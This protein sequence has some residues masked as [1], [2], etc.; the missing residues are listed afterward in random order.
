MR[1]HSAIRRRS[2]ASGSRRVARATPWLARW[3]LAA[4]LALSVV[5]ASGGRPRTDPSVPGGLLVR[6]PHTIEALP[7]AVEG[8]HLGESLHPLLDRLRRDGWRVRTRGLHRRGRP[9][10][11]VYARRRRGGPLRRLKMNFISGRLATLR[12]YYRAGRRQRALDLATICSGW[13]RAAPT[14]LY[15]TCLDPQRTTAWRIHHR[16]AR[17]ELVDLRTLL[18]TGFVTRSYVERQVRRAA[19]SPGPVAR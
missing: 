2:V 19:S 17:V 4:S 8:F 11:R 9:Y 5:P 1:S 7:R 10:T 15:F 14:R 12:L 13:Q 18:R 6:I 3:T 16:G